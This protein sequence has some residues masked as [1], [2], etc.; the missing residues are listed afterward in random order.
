MDMS[1][2]HEADKAA[3]A[4]GAAG[5]ELCYGCADGEE[6]VEYGDYYCDGDGG[7]SGYHSGGVPG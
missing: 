5:E 7:V 1:R 2:L 4:E 3:G 6:G